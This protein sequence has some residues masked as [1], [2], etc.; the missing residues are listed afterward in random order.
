MWKVHFSMGTSMSLCMLSNLPVF[1]MK[2]NPTMFTSWEG[3]CMDWNKH[4]E[5]G[6]RDWGISYS[7]RDSRWNWHH[8]LHQEAW[9]WLVCNAN[10][11]W[12]YHIWV[13]KSRFLWGVWQDALL[14]KLYPRWAFLVFCGEH[15]RPPRPR[16]HGKSWLNRGGRPRLTDLPRRTPFVARHGYVH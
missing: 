10:L 11:C 2:R 3:L 13:N 6:M 16:G 1:K 12:W 5:H 8:S 4:L 15:S 7:L 14:H 9:K